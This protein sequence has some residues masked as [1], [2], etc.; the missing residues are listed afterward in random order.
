QKELDW[1]NLDQIEHQKQHRFFKDLAQVYR[2]HNALYQYDHHPQGFSWSVVDD[3]DQSVFAYIRSSDDE[4]LVVVLNMT[5]NV[6][7]TYEIGVP[8][9]GRYQEILNSDKEIYHGSNQY[10]GTQL[11]TTKGQRN[12]FKYYIKPKLGP[13]A[14]IILQFKK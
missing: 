6:H 12:G 11:Y 10:N 4:I 13:L 1:H 7:H 3:K 14:G 8:R 5:P 2:H 9:A